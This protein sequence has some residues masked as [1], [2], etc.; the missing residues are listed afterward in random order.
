MQQ[1]NRVKKTKTISKGVTFFRLCDITRGCKHSSLSRGAK[2]PVGLWEKLAVESTIS[3]IGAHRACP[4]AGNPTKPAR[5]QMT[6]SQRQHRWLA[7]DHLEQKPRVTPGS[8]GDT[9]GGERLKNWEGAG[10]GTETVR[11]ETNK[12]LRSDRG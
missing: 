11:S 6:A 5:R 1:L 4:R 7:A 9:T 12:E 8:Q 3:I 10:W 2:V